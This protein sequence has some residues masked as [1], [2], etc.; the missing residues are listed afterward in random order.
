MTLKYGVLILDDQAN[1]RDLLSEIL[2]N[3]FNAQCVSSYDEAI[4]AIQGQ[5]PPFHVVVTDMRLN[6]SEAGNE[7]GL[8]L[9]EY[10]NKRGDETNTIVVTG[11]PT[12]ETAKRALKTL[13]AYDYLEKHPSDGTPFDTEMLKRTV[14]MAA[15]EAEKRR[16]RGVTN[17][18]HSILV[19]ES[20]P[21][22]RQ[23]IEN[24]LQKDGYR[25]ETLDKFDNL[26]HQLN[27]VEAD[28]ALILISESLYSETVPN[29][30][31]RLFPDGTVV[32]L[33]QKD[34][35]N[36]LD[37]LHEFPV[38]AFALPNEKFNNNSFNE[39]IHRILS[40][41]ASRYITW[42][43][44]PNNRLD[45]NHVHGEELLKES[46]YSIELSL[47][48]APASDAIKVLLWPPEE[49]N[50]RI[51]VHIFIHAEQM[52]L[53]LGTEIHWDVSPISKR[54][55]SISFTIV[56]QQIG[57]KQLIIDFDQNH[58]FLGRI[59]TKLKVIDG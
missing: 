5:E 17:V 50:Q 29:T 27:H 31:H 46:E 25:V 47:Q 4:K 15:Q 21:A 37:A 10:L 30:L 42:R 3:Q 18:N 33:T 13:N 20:D 39:F 48:D 14:N 52:K 54:P 12:I 34:I 35:S 7:G 11:Y 2:E 41:E 59:A 32:I 51:R 55:N 9:I 22:W 57:E 49:K 16:P 40:D 8:K 23:K 53:E 26:E 56:P 1:W 6:D 45:K 44:K 43:I 36:I 24:A 19:L 28:F 38:E 58:R